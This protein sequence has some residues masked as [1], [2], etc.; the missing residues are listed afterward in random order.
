MDSKQNNNELL[1]IIKKAFGSLLSTGIPLF[2]VFVGLKVINEPSNALLIILIYST[3]LVGAPIWYFFKIVAVVIYSYF[4]YLL[5]PLGLGAIFLIVYKK[6]VS[7]SKDSE[8]N[9]ES[10][11]SKQI[12]KDI[13]T[14]VKNNILAFDRTIQKILPKMFSFCVA[15]L[16]YAYMQ[17]IFIFIIL[18]MSF[19]GYTGKHGFSVAMQGEN[20]E[21][22]QKGIRLPFPTKD[23]ENKLFKQI[24]EK[25]R[26]FKE[27]NA[28]QLFCEVLQKLPE[29]VETSSHKN[30]NPNL[31]ET[32][33]KTLL[34]NN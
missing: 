24:E 10:S 27:F 31:P 3:L 14:Y 26:V 25:A 16:F 5:F 2:I 28:S 20:Y 34:K 1:S 29:E 22:C 33:K 4:P 23:L 7:S 12:E 9:K 6:V 15:T 17:F 13:S 19:V 11:E 8:N 18:M 21:K 30:D 32:A